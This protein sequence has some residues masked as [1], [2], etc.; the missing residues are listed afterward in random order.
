MLCEVLISLKIDFYLPLYNKLIV[1]GS[2]H[3]MN[4]LR[5][6]LLQTDVNLPFGVKQGSYQIRHWIVE[7]AGRK[8]SSLVFAFS[9][10]AIGS[11]TVAQV[12][13]EFGI[14]SLLLHE[15]QGSARIAE[16]PI[17]QDLAIS[18]A[19]ENFHITCTRSSHGDQRVLAFDIPIAKK[20]MIP[21][22]HQ[23]NQETVEVVHRG[24]MPKLFRPAGAPANCETNREHWEKIV[25]KG[26]PSTRRKTILTPNDKMPRSVTRF[27]FLKDHTFSA[28][29]TTYEVTFA[30][31]DGA[32]ILVPAIVSELEA[33][34]VLQEI[35]NQY[36]R[37]KY[38]DG[39]LVIILN[40]RCRGL[41][42]RS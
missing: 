23:F 5:L 41:R 17:C 28:S 31:E 42:R 4:Q 21:Y 34:N 26:L 7:T 39:P 16:H 11:M 12:Q 2:G 24:G 33:F 19:A 3:Y 27:G 22:Q 20:S 40:F 30:H 8:H 18:L 35:I 1:P 25:Y 38:R 32:F 14:H 37:D 6:A 9:K 13:A 29:Q 36:P 10:S 15:L